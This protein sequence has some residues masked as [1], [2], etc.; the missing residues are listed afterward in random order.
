MARRPR[1][2]A[3]P[4][5]RS[6]Q[7]SGPI[8]LCHRVAGPRRN[9]DGTAFVRRCTRLVQDLRSTASR[10]QRRC[11]RDAA[12]GSKRAPPRVG[13][14]RRRIAGADR[15]PHRGRG[16]AFPRARRR[17]L[18]GLRERGVG[19][20]RPIAR[21]TRPARRIDPDHAARCDARSEAR[22]QD[23]RAH[24]GAEMG[25]GAGGARTRAHMVE[26]AD[27]RGLSQPHLVPRRALRHRRRR[28]RAV[29][30]G[31][32]WT[33]RPRRGD[34]GRAAARAERARTDGGATR[35]HR[36]RDGQRRDRQ[37]A[38]VRGRAR[39]H[40]GR[41]R[42]RA[43]QRRRIQACATRQ[44]GAASGDAVAQ[45]TGRARD[46]HAR[47]RPAAPRGARAARAPGRA[48]RPR[49]RRRRA[50]GDRQRQ[51]RRA[52]VGGLEWRLI[53]GRAGRRRD[54]ASD[55]QARRSSRSSTRRRSIR[56]CSPPHRWSTTARSRSPPS[57]ARTCRRTTIATFAAP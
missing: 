55:R 6:R 32:R 51:R 3:D 18:A 11:A 46:H 33:R 10:P 5:T 15:D 45:D 12:R 20:R 7:L 2:M 42:R 34:P 24:L 17:R 56:A 9:H 37:R 36:R 30:Q 28:S 25:P 27:S 8:F 21:R 41:A 26:G 57:A 54:R 40:D 53:R 1:G 16:Q 48:R 47:R 19:Q 39:E 29:R 43:R 49:R 52:G 31:A 44:C 23:R 14:A 35:M 22:D 50:G 4:Q 13:R 38:R